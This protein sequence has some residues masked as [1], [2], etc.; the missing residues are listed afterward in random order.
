MMQFATQNSGPSLADTMTAARTH[1]EPALIEQAS[2]STR[3]RD[4]LKSNPHAAIRDLLGN[5]PVPSLNIRVVEE[6]PGEITVV[7]PR[8]IAQDEL[9][10]EVLDYAAG[11]NAQECWNQFKND[12]LFG[13]FDKKK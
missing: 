12:W 2:A 10:D 8:A 4:L 7:L 3:F 9:P 1:I 11:G 13:R 5:D 6:Q